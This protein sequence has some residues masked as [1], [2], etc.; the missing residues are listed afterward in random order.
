MVPLGQVSGTTTPRPGAPDA[1]LP[2]PEDREGGA[3]SDQDQDPDGDS[4]TSQDSLCLEVGV[5]EKHRPPLVDTGE[6][7]PGPYGGLII[8]I[9]IIIIID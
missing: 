1:R 7:S 2:G 3:S 5:I 9:I 4:G 6:P 8:I